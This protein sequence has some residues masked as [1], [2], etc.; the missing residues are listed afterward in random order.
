MIN[1]NHMFNAVLTRILFVMKIN[2]IK[3]QGHLRRNLLGLKCQIL[4]T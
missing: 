2:V 3:C 1:F 4:E